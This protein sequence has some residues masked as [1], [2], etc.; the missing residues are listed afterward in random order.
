MAIGKMSGESVKVTGEDLIWNTELEV[1][2]FY[3]MRGHK[4]VGV[5]KNFQMM[6]IHEKFNQATGRQVTSK[7]IWDHLETLYDMQALHESEIL[8]FPNK[9]VDFSLPTSE[10][11]E[12]MQQRGKSGEPFKGFSSS[13]HDSEGSKSDSARSSI[14]FGTPSGVTAGTPSE[15]DNSPKRKRTRQAGTPT[16]TPSTKRRR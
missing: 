7:Q 15:K 12:M 3:A 2:L 13:S 1:S 9:E 10:F 8:P 5:N 16:E 14:K 11:Q 4:P 6:C